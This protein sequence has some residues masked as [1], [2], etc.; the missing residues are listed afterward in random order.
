MKLTDQD[1]DLG[2]RWRRHGGLAG[3]VAVLLRLGAGVR[4]WKGFSRRSMEGRFEQEA[5]SLVQGFLGVAFWGL[6]GKV[7]CKVVITEGTYQ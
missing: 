1:L 3:G 6:G 4:F 2:R 7:P 5:T